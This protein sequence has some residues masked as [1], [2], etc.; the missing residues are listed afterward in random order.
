MINVQINGRFR[1]LTGGAGQLE[2]EAATIRQLFRELEKRYPA[3][4]PH[5]GEG[6]AVAINGEIFQDGWLEPIPPDAEVHIIP[7]VVGG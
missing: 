6:I 2:I 1:H 5:L 7:M 3:I 4:G